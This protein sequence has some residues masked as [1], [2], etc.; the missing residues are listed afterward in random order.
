MRGT[1]LLCL[2]LTSVFLFSQ[3]ATVTS[4]PED[5]QL[6]PRNLTTNQAIINV[7]GQV[8]D[9]GNSAIF[10]EVTK[11]GQFLTN[12]VINLTGNANQPFSF[13]FNLP[14]ELHQYGFKLIISRSGT[15]TIVQQAEN[16]VAGDVFVVQ[17]QSNAY[18][19]VY[20]GASYT[21]PNN[22]WVRSY[23]TTTL[24][25]NTVLSDSSWHQATAISTHQGRIGIWAMKL[26]ELLSAT[27]QIPV[28][29]LNGSKSGT[30]ITEHQYN[31]STNSLYGQLLYR[32]Q[33]ASVANNIRAIIWWQG[34]RDAVGDLV[35]NQQDYYN[36][37]TALR[38]S[39]INDFPALEKIYMTQLHTVYNEPIACQ[40]REA[41]RLLDVDFQDIR[42]QTPYNI[43]YFDNNSHHEPTGYEAYGQRIFHLI[44]DDLYGTTNME[45]DPPK[46]I[47]ASYNGLKTRIKLEFDQPVV[48]QSPITISGA[49][50]QDLR[51]YFY[52]D[53]IAGLVDSTSVIG[54]DLFLFLQQSVSAQYI[55]YLP[56]SR[57]N[58]S[59]IVYRGP[60]LTNSQGLGAVSWYNSPIQEP[61]FP[62]EL[63]V[64]LEG[65]FVDSLGQM[66]AS[67]NQP[68]QVLPGQTNSNVPSIHPYSSAPWNYGGSEG[69]GFTNLEYND[70]V[71][72]WVLVSLRTDTAAA[73]SLYSVAGLL[74]TNG[75][76]RFVEQPFISFN[77]QD[78]F[79]IVVEHRN[80]MGV[81]T[82]SPVKVMN[83]RVSFDFTT[84]DSYNSA[85][86]SYGSKEVAPGVWA[87]IASDGDQVLDTYSYDI[88]GRDKQLWLNENGTFSGYYNADYNLSGE[89]TGADRIIWHSNNGFS[90][91][92]PR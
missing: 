16:V 56:A 32:A 12:Q 23:G 72:D 78:S 7:V 43:G 69:L 27:N 90:S 59:T 63:K 65:G 28:A 85:G 31:T 14:A 13:S 18:A 60:W 1:T 82:P 20:G 58:N 79:F 61:T 55:S 76:F 40:I 73:T 17:G 52:L 4:F 71:V 91:R 21:E 54:N 46:L 48:W 10:L 34:E 8:T 3:Q 50:V 11:D 62:I 24:D 41:Q 5:W 88:N 29:I 92:V 44:M 67:L 19:R 66:Q 68:R 83:G 77:P 6:A 36:K 30:S 2:L 39:W 53:G 81:M 42:I 33:Q 74:D 51:D 70:Q 22:Q 15:S 49:G 9:A 86:T 80:H 35:P 84:Q 26:G 87:M 75:R 25:P 57:Y 89:V 64:Y 45:I 37:F 38:S 47:T